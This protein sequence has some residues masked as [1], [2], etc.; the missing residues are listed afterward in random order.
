MKNSGWI[1][2]FTGKQFWPLDPKIKDIC[3]EDIAHGLSMICRFNG[4]CNRFYSVAEH[5]LLVSHYVNPVY[6]FHG[7]MHDAA[8]AYI[9]DMA[10][11]VKDKMM[12]YKAIENK[13]QS[14]INERFGIYNFDTWMVKEVDQRILVDEMNVLMPNQPADWG[15]NVSGFGAIPELMTP[16]E[17]EKLF[18][19]RFYEL[20][21]G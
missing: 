4:Q 13:L 15:H 18:L 10:K 6:A 17:S 3:I 8:E 1:Q 14:A 21:E 20:Y 7:L 16:D 9:S 12:A 2:T 11:P 19:K 5:S